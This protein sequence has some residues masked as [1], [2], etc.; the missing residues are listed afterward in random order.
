MSE[1]NNPYNAPESDVHVQNTEL[2]DDASRWL[3]LFAALI[4]AIIAMIVTIPLMLYYGI[5]ELAMQGKELGFQYT[6]MFASLGIVAFMLFHGYLLRTKGQT[7]GKLAL[8]IKIV[9][10]EGELPPFGKLIG[11]RYLPLWLLQLVPAVNLLAIVDV[12]FIFRGDRRCVHDLI[13]G[14]KV[15]RIIE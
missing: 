15:V 8:G 3:R 7:V 4:D 6:L 12:L 14:T 13:A 11:L 1:Q 2:K 9:T 5:F 10:L